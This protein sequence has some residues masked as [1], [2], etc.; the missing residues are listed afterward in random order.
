[1]SCTVILR[2]YKTL[3]GRQVGNG[4]VHGGGEARVRGAEAVD[5]C[6]HTCMCMYIS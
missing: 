4:L 6:V 1:M 3:W 5:G 2:H